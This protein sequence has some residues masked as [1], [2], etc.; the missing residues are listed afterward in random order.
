MITIAHRL[1]TIMDYDKIVSTPFCL[2]HLTRLA[3]TAFQMVL[4][5]GELVEFD[6]PK[7]LLV[8][9][10]GVFS[11]LVEESE[12]REILKAMVIS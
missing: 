11:A 3:V 12:D 1:Q 4:D 7:N 9:K 2:V 6:T 10:G 8:K 5:A